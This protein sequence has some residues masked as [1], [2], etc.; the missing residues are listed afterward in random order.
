MLSYT[1]QTFLGLN[2][3]SEGQALARTTTLVLMSSLNVWCQILLANVRDSTFNLHFCS[4]LPTLIFSDILQVQ[5]SLHCGVQQCTRTGGNGGGQHRG[6]P[7]Q[8]LQSPKG[9]RDAYTATWRRWKCITPPQ[10]PV[11]FTIV[12]FSVCPPCPLTLF[13]D[14]R[15]GVSLWAQGLREPSH[16]VGLLPLM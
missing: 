11:V 10:Q 7:G 8:S 1:Y 12:W 15:P 13:C 16:R 14:I 3:S 2:D 6:T 5:V 9:E 4:Y